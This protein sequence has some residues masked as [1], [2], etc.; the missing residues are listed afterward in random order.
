[1][2]KKP[3]QPP[4]LPSGARYLPDIVGQGYR[5][6]WECRRRYRVVKGG[7]ASK[8]SSTT[9]LWYIVHMMK[10][11][12]ANVMVIRNVYRTHENS[13]FAQL[14]W[15]IRRL[16]VEAL[17]T[18]T[19]SPL[20]LIYKPTGQRILFRGMDRV[21]KLAST[22][23]ERGSICWVWIEEAFELRSEEDFNKLD[24][25]MPRGEVA[26][27]LFKQTTITFN[28]WS[29]QHWLKARFF[30][31]PHPDVLAMTTNYL[32]N[33]W[34]DDTD[35]AIYEDMRV[36]FPR[37]YAVAGLG[38]WGVEEGLVFERW[39]VE[40]FDPRAL[41][42]EYRHVFGLDY[43]YANDPTAFIAAAVSA[44]QRR[45]YIYDEHYEKRMLNSD[46]ARMI[47]DKGYAKERIRADS[48]EPKSNEE[49][50][51]LGLGR[52][53]PAIKGADSV[54]HGIARLQ[55]YEMVVHPACRHTIAELSAYC[56]EQDAA[57]R[58]INRPADRDNHLM[59]A[60]RYAMADV[61]PPREQ[62][63]RSVPRRD[64][65]GVLPV[66]FRGHWA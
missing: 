13:T 24:L 14:K 12:D 33:E 47:R 3:K 10:Y 29:E 7:K 31:Q 65:S 63:P 56:W 58:T 1:M 57:G 37:R 36:R 27:P 52:I 44:A 8:K 22:T 50:R 18:A 6:F 49:L 43:G 17:W 45:L 51:R 55:E 15:A 38:E 48:A 9:A 42:E 2:M 64:P 5:R 59:D 53:A 32:C 39:R 61:P 20:E 60:L 23:V 62:A 30:D 40:S 21:D 25:S 28:P 19:R 11:P 66:H 46:I 16:G 34:L 4:E 26:P 41:P 35:R 54:L